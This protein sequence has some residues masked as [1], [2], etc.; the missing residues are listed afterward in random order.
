[1]QVAAGNGY[2]TNGWAITIASWTLVS[3]PR[4]IRLA[5]QLVTAVGGSVAGV[6]G[7]WIEDASGNVL[8]WWE[9]SAITLSPGDTL[10]LDDLTVG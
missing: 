10:P 4:S 9:R 2:P 3:S 5:D 6:A 1:V 7:A 8:V